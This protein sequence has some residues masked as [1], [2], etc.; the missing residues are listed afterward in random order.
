MGAHCMKSCAL[1]ARARACVFY[2]GSA[3]QQQKVLIVYCCA[4]RSGRECTKSALRALRSVGT[5]H[6]EVILCF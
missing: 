3:T 5:G 4:D 6:V 2:D 1:R